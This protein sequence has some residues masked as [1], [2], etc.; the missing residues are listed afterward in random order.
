LRPVGLLGLL[1]V[2]GCGSP[3]VYNEQ[4]EGVVQIDG[5]PL[6]NVRVEFVPLV[7]GTKVPSSSAVT[8]QAGHYRLTC[9]NGKSG[10]VVGK[11]RV[12]LLQGRGGGRNPEDDAPAVKAP[13][14]SNPPIPEVYTLAAKTPL[15]ITVEKGKT[16]YDLKV[17]RNPPV[18]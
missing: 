16:T 8:D 5:V 11:H 9:D 15:E 17:S 12:V 3:L 6:T 13:Q 4:V 2:C 7:E 18:R 14:P 10:A 1:M